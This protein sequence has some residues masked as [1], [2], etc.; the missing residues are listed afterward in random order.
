MAKIDESLTNFKKDVGKDV[1]SYPKISDA[2]KDK[3]K[4]ASE[5]ATDANRNIDVLYDSPNKNKIVSKFDKIINGAIAKINSSLSSELDVMI[6]KANQLLALIGELGNLIDDIGPLESIVSSET[7]TEEA[8]ASAQSELDSKI[9]TFNDKHREALNMLNALK[10]MDSTL[11]LVKEFSTTNKALDI[12]GFEY[13]E[14]E[15]HT[16]YQGKDV[17]VASN[18]VRLEYYLYIP[19]YN[20]EIP[21]NANLLTSIHGG[22]GSNTPLSSLTDYEILYKQI[23]N[24]K[25]IPNG[26]V[27]MPHIENFNGTIRSDRRPENEA[28]KE[29]IDSVVA[30]YDI[31]PNGVSLSGHSFGGLMATSMDR[32]YPDSFASITCM[33]GLYSEIP[34]KVDGKKYWVISCS[35]DRN[36]DSPNINPGKVK[37]SVEKLESMGADVNY[38]YLE[39]VAHSNTD[40][41]VYL[42]P[43][44]TANGQTVNLLQWQLSQT[45]DSN[46]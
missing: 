30:K 2:L 11:A 36:W 26:F 22:S 13:G 20:G 31:N 18:G 24:Q 46:K 28:L 45:R 35:G 27:L 41:V 5:A 9:S 6:E 32:D 43:M 19:K 40:D 16:K 44:K 14:F 4:K 37:E 10:G 42:N 17:F 7:A 29:L 25:I 38:T 1:N 33:S 3:L 39:E 34:K 8:K 21:K 12:D 23:A 15:K